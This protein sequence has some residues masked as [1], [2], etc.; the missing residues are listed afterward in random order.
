M[1]TFCGLDQFFS[2]RCAHEENTCFHF[3]GFFQCK[4]RLLGI[5]GFFPFSCYGTCIFPE[6]T[7]L[8]GSL[9][10]LRRSTLCS[11][12]ETIISPFKNVLGNL[13][14]L[15]K[16]NCFVRSSAVLLVLNFFVPRNARWFV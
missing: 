12:L 14:A 13:G 10:F 2:W 6:E 11:I 3:Y 1:E 7:K 9:V 4:C 16:Y 8:Q 5:Q 15:S